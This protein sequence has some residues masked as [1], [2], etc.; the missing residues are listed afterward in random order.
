M[1]TCKCGRE[2]TGLTECHCS[3]CHRQ[4]SSIGPFDT[5]R[6]GDRCNDPA[7]MTTKTGRARFVALGR[8]NGTV[9]AAWFDQS[10]KLPADAFTKQVTP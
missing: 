7:E 1:T 5:H 8:K 10:K 2:W 4:F 6:T 9:W 3:A